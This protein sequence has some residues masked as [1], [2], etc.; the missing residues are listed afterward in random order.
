MMAPMLL[1]RRLRL[2]LLAALVGL[3]S[4]PVAGCATGTGAAE[5][6]GA[7]ATGLP[8]GVLRPG[9]VK[10]FLLTADGPWPVWREIATT[11]DPQAALDELARGPQDTERSRG[12][13]SA[14]PTNALGLTATTSDGRVDIDLPWTIQV[15][16]HEAVSQMACTAASAPA[17]PGS[18]LYT[19]V[20]IVFHEPLDESNGF[21]VHCGADGEAKV[22]AVS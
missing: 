11:A 12:I 13:G 17:I 18:L 15:I 16:D 4:I 21:A 9:S 19:D 6:A 7:P 3:A 2:L 10:I 22:G 5:T 14:L 20:L 1:I 8:W